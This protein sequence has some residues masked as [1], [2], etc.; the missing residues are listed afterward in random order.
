[1][2]HKQELN[3]HTASIKDFQLQMRTSSEGS[4]ETR[5]KSKNRTKTKFR[6]IVDKLN[7]LSMYTFKVEQQFNTRE[8]MY[9]LFVQICITIGIFE[10]VIKKSNFK[11]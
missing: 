10:S 4:Y 5:L 9:Y 6:F 3:F 2:H 11:C 7:R 1:M 8:Q